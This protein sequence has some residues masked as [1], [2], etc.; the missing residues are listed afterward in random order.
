MVSVIYIPIKC[1]NIIYRTQNLDSIDF[2][3]RY[4]T[5]IS[6]LKISGPLCYQFIWVFYF[7]RAVYA[8]VFVIFQSKPSLQLAFAN[9]ITI[10]MLLYL[11]VVKPYDSLL[12]TILSVVNEVMIISM[13]TSTFRFLNS[14][15]TPSMSNIIGNMFAGIIVGT[16]AI[17]WFA[18]IGYGVG[19]YIKKYVSIPLKSNSLQ[20][21]TL[22]TNIERN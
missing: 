9:T 4:K 13:I 19:T 8:S 11:L 14:V 15:I 6:G 18:I 16:I 5:I 22:I 3:K 7:R 12:S 21:S 1:F 10:V 17:N 2:Q 20:N